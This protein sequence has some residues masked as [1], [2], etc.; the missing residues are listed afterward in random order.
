MLTAIAA[1]LAL[2]GCESP[3]TRKPIDEP[4]TGQDALDA[5]ERMQRDANAL[6]RR[7]GRQRPAQHRRLAN[8]HSRREVAAFA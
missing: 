7:E 1:A 6:L 8:G 5:G 2:A 3:D 4:L